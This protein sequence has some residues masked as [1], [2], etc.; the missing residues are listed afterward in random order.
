MYFILL[1]FGWVYDEILI[2]SSGFD[3]SIWNSFYV[4]NNHRIHFELLHVKININ[5]WIFADAFYTEIYAKNWKWNKVW[6]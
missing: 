3:Y 2:Y 1:Y 5:I 6:N 4:H